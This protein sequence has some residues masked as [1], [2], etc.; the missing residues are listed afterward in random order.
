M[1]GSTCS[2]LIALLTLGSLL[3]PGASTAV[4][5]RTGSES[6]DALFDLQSFVDNAIARGGSTIVLPP[7]RHRVAPTGGVHLRL[8]GLRDVTIVADGVEI[9]C[10]KTT[11]AIDIEDCHNLKLS[12]LSIDYDPLPYTQ[13]RIVELSKDK[14]VHEIELFDGYPDAYTATTKKYQIFR[15][16]D[17]SLRWVDYFDPKVEA[18]TSNRLRVTKSARDPA[19]KEEV[20]DLIV[21]SSGHDGA[22]TLPHAVVL[23]SCSGVRLDRV[24]VYASNCFAFLENDCKENV[25]ERCHVTKRAE[26]DDPVPRAVPR[27]RSANA[28]AFHSKRATKGPQIVGC[29]AHYQGDDCVNINGD[30]HLIAD[31]TDRRLRVIAKQ[32]MDIRRGDLAELTDRRGAV[33]P[34]A[35]VVSIRKSGALTSRDRAMVASLDLHATLKT[36][37]AGRLATVYELELD[38]AVSLDPGSLIASINR[39]GD[40]FTVADCDFGHVRSRGI[41]VKASH[42]DIRDNRLTACRSESIKLAAEGYWLESG[43]ASDVRILRNVIS[44]CG[45]VAIAVY[46]KGYATGFADGAA[47][48]RI[49]IADNHISD[50]P[51]PN[52]L[53]TSTESIRLEGNHSMRGSDA[54]PSDHSLMRT[55]A[56]ISAK[57]S[58]ILLHECTDVVMEANTVQ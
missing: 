25:Y 18:L 4:V 24:T 41:I 54:P 58:P 31:A 40:G 23:A 27:L 5:T 33:L 8:K 15:Q 42:G 26:T 35:R 29:Y 11:R 21:I 1:S 38:R 47:H 9:V 14:R 53:V 19:P 36:H 2:T 48:R 20:G 39:R 17:A 51:L 3:V 45:S 46:A 28:D 16:S 52:V 6:S 56:R 7:G 10:T 49:T 50:S 37:A 34:E 22:K 13:G 44:D 12:G 32:S 57:Q 43:S 55:V 30:Y